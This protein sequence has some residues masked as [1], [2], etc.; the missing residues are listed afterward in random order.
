VEIEA[1]ARANPNNPFVLF[2]HAQTLRSAGDVEGGLLA[3]RK[4]SA[5]LPGDIR[6]QRQV[7]LAQFHASDAP[8][9]IASF[10]NM[11]KANPKDID[12]HNHLTRFLY[13]SGDFDGG[14]EAAQQLSA[15]APD[16]GFGH[17]FKALSLASRGK[18]ADA[19]EAMTLALGTK[20]P[21]VWAFIAK[22][23]ISRRKG[24]FDEAIAAGRETIVSDRQHSRAYAVLGLAL[25]ARG[26]TQEGLQQLQRAIELAPGYAFQSSLEVPYIAAAILETHA[27]DAVLRQQALKWLQQDTALWR[28]R[29]T[30]NPMLFRPG[31]AFAIKKQLDDPRFAVVRGAATAKLPPEDRA[32]WEKLWQDCESLRKDAEK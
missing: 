26:Q 27:E 16:W 28:K 7:A 3:A 6:L 25:L 22:S 1:V 23:D 9:A 21:T 32:A 19:A 18:L 15:L 29:L 2:V 17:G 24:Q 4:Y 11:L 5:L 8:T 30:S 31:V 12:C 20:N 14:I 10:R 13:A